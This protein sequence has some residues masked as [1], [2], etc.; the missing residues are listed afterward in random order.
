MHIA[1]SRT[2][3]T[4]KLYTRYLEHLLEDIVISCPVA[5]PS[6]ARTTLGANGKFPCALSMSSAI[7]CSLSLLSCSCFVPSIYVHQHTK[8]RAGLCFNMPTPLEESR[9]GSR[10]FRC[11]HNTDDV[12]NTDAPRDRDGVGFHSDLHIYIQH[13]LPLLSDHISHLDIYLT[14]FL[15]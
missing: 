1:R 8:D 2:L 6:Q 11:S 4:M 13:R 5:G 3:Q 10:Q 15:R 12:N 7:V 14:T 9:M